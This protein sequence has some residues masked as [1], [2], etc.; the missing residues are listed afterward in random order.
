MGS[1][2]TQ[3][4]ISTTSSH[5]WTLILNGLLNATARVLRKELTAQEL[6]LWER[7]LSNCR[8]DGLE[9][10]FAEHLRSSKFFPMPAE[11]TELYE[12]W[13]AAEHEKKRVAAEREERE[14]TERRRDRGETFGIAEVRREF[15]RIVS[16]TSMPA[17]EPTRRVEL[18]QQRARIMKAIEKARRL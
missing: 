9:W 2:P 3:D 4:A 6:L 12:T 17:P 18:Y 10:A 16:A 5:S 13:I 8:I 7:L 14:E 1:P 11:I 15:N